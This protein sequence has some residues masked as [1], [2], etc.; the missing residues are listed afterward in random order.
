MSLPEGGS[1]KRSL[2]ISSLVILF[3][4]WKMGLRECWSYE[5]RRMRGGAWSLYDAIL[6]MLSK[7]HAM[8]LPTPA[9]CV[10]WPERE[11]ERERHREPENT[12]RVIGRSNPKVHGTPFPLCPW[13]LNPET[14]PRV[15][16]GAFE[17]NVS[18][19]NGVIVD[20]NLCIG[21]LWGWWSP[22]T[23]HHTLSPSSESSS[24]VPLLNTLSLPYKLRRG[25]L[26][27]VSR[28][29]DLTSQGMA[30]APPRIL[31][32]TRPTW[33][34]DGVRIQQVQVKTFY[35]SSEVV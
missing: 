1:C 12:C 22:L 25:R 28:K 34:Q 21:A 33:N 18:F 8:L 9:S 3:H 31:W 11:R 26:Q 4:E 30:K 10:F 14:P 27:M 35:L 29:W 17:R 19:M 13:S 15:S 7:L 6:W 24:S 20:D 32:A 5:W 16:V 2:R 23:P